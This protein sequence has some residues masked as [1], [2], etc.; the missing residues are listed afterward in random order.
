[1]LADSAGGQAIAVL[2]MLL[3]NLYG[4]QATNS[5]C[6]EILYTLSRELL[7]IDSAIASPSQLY[8]VMHIVSSKMAIAGFGKLVSSSSH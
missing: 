8:Q 4:S 1:M 6:G 3:P 2:L 5:V 7:P